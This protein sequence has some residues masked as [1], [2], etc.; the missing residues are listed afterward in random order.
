LSSYTIDPNNPTANAKLTF[1][2]DFQ[3]T[4]TLSLT[5]PNGQNGVWN[6]DYAYNTPNDPN[7]HNFLPSNG[8][9]QWY[10]A[11]TESKTNGYSPFSI[12]SNG[13]TIQATP[14]PSNLLSAVQNQPYLSGSINTQGTF[15]Q[16]YGLFEIKAQLPS[17][18]GLWPA[19]WLLPENGQWPP[20]IDVLESIGNNSQFYTT[21]HANSLANGYEN[22]GAQTVPNPGGFNTYAVDWEPDYTTFYIDGKQVYQAATPKDLNLP[23]YLIA[24]LAVGGNWPGDPNSS[25]HF[26]AQYNISWIKAYQSNAA[27]AAGDA[28]QGSAAYYGTHGSGASSGSG[29]S[30]GGGSSTGSGSGTGASSGS[31]SG[32]STGGSSSGGGSA[33][34]WA[35]HHH[36]GDGHHVLHQGH[37]QVVLQNTN[38]A[39][40]VGNVV[41]GHA[42]HTQVGPVGHEWSVHLGHEWSF[43]M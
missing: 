23:Q 17:G 29:S 40:D 37:D 6:T 15:S 20:E 8:E 38:G 9:Q 39:V 19:F 4:Q 41:S 34:F 18:Q 36:S 16:E 26:P 35:S 1:D 32:G 30:S 28:P 11:N 3:A 21:I 25:T 42:Q 7:A 31:G 10:V 13:L 2:S 43:H 33:P 12:N 27:L 5:N 22:D 14:T 24:N